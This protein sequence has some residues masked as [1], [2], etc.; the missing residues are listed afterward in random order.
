M[1]GTSCR[2][3]LPAR[4]AAVTAPHSG[5]TCV[6]APFMEP[7]PVSPGTGPGSAQQRAELY[8][9]V[10]T[11]GVGLHG[12]LPPVGGQ[13]RD[14]VVV[15]AA[16]HV[17]TSSG[18]H[19]VTIP[20]FRLGRAQDVQV[21][22]YAPSAFPPQVVVDTVDRALVAGAGRWNTGDFLQGDHVV[23]D[24]QVVG[25]FPSGPALVHVPGCRCVTVRR[26]RKP[27]ADWIPAARVRAHLLCELAG[28]V[29]SSGAPDHD[30]PYRRG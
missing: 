1:P 3:S 5:R 30:A 7:A 2:R 24:C 20:R 4:G 6:S 16:V 26:I 9:P 25:A 21:T 15:F 19:E 27:S 28:G 13:V 10:V 17:R 23:S 22:L 14:H 12:R 29:S 11:A 18:V 8:G